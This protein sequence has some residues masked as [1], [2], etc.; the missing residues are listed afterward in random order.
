MTKTAQD[1]YAKNFLLRETMIW[2]AMSAVGSSSIKDPIA[3]LNR[4]E[5]KFGPIVKEAV[6]LAYAEVSNNCLA[7]A[8]DNIDK[9]LSSKYGWATCQ[10]L[11]NC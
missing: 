11:R 4:Q 2:K 6:S 7:V 5:K 8:K 3:Y 10:E 1:L 9:L